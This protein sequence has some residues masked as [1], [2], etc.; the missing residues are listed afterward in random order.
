METVAFVAGAA[1]VL[2][3]W[4]LAPQ[5]AKSLRI[6]STAGLSPTW[7][8]FGVAINLG[9]GAYR[10]SQDLWL[11]VFSPAIAAALYVGLLWL[12]LR[13]ASRRRGAFL[14]LLGVVCSLSIAATIGGWSLVGTFLGLWAGVQVAP[15]VASA[16]RTGSPLA[17]APGLW[18]IGLA[19]A[20]LWG[21]YG[22]AVGD[23]ALALYGVTM[24]TGSAAI[25]LRLVTRNLRL[26][27]LAKESGLVIA[28]DA[29]RN[30][31][32]HPVTSQLHVSSA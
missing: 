27:R 6:K 4:Q 2:S 24:G 9:W 3:A 13:E 20:A 14:A 23:M 10:W 11:S 8:A 31:A 26:R 18:I 30:G 12:V 19:Q 29:D 22:Y 17:I 7:A 15:A 25:L 1:T 5:L 16:F 28:G 32:P 21:Y